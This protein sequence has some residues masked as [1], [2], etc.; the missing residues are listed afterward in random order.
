VVGRVWNVV[1][2]GISGRMLSAI[3]LIVA[4]QVVLAALLFGTAAVDR[5]GA[6]SLVHR[7]RR[8]RQGGPLTSVRAH[9]RRISSL[10]KATERSLESAPR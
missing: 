7:L 9:Q 4:S 6:R 2:G 1:G 3:A 10:R 5:P 8:R